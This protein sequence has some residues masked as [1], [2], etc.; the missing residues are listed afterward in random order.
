MKP[1]PAVALL[2]FLDIPAGI[3]ATD[4]MLKKAPIVFL[5]S[6]TI[7]RGR[8]LTVIGGT[9]AS[10]EEAYAEGEYW[11]GNAIIDRLFLPDVHPDV[12][13]AMFGKRNRSRDGAW[14]IIETAS[15]AANIRAAEAALKGTPVSLLELRLADDGLAGKG[16]SF[17]EGHLHD[18]EA[19]VDI[20]TA[21]LA[22][23]GTTFS[24]RILTAPHEALG[25]HIAGNTRFHEVDALK[26][27]G[28]RT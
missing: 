23:S 5:K 8:Y 26:L 6:G 2:E 21:F 15:V 4:A 12:F 24:Y 3:Q 20:A 9:T 28:E 14:A 7:T 1:F 27:D 16:L 11:A 22:R 19:A 17:Y 13:A 25:R 10:V 18:I